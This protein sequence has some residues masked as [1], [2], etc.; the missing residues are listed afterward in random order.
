[1]FLHCPAADSP[2]INLLIKTK[3]TSSPSAFVSRPAR[4]ASCGLA[5]CTNMFLFV[6]VFFF[7]FCLWTC[8]FLFVPEEREVHLCFTDKTQLLLILWL[9]WVYAS[10]GQTARSRWW[11]SYLSSCD[12]WGHFP[13]TSI[14]GMMLTFLTDWIPPV[15][16]HFVES[17]QS[18]PRD[19]WRNW[20]ISFGEYLLKAQLYL[21][22]KCQNFLII[23]NVVVIIVALF[24]FMIFGTVIYFWNPKFIVLFW[25]VIWLNLRI[26]C[27]PRVYS[28]FRW[29]TKSP[30]SI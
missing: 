11:S 17:K 30:N 7:S 13:C 9:S 22:W 5:S 19:V 10:G 6:G 24:V 23:S 2:L 20:I 18:R 16:V 8:G 25:C 14:K 1:M 29:W 12:A 15:D 21:W 4:L 3:W 26:C 28:I 27:N